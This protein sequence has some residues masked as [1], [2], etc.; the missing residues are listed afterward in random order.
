MLNQV[1]LF[2]LQHPLVPL[3]VELSVIDAN[4][5]AGY[6]EVNNQRCVPLA[7]VIYGPRHVSMVEGM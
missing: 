6:Q 2:G 4:P 3:R 7:R 1:L 5:D